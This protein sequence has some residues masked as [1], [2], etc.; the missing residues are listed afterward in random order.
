MISRMKTRVST[1]LMPQAIALVVLV[2]LSLALLVLTLLPSPAAAQAPAPAPGAAASGA[3][4]TQGRDVT[5][6][7][8]GPADGPA[9]GTTIEFR[10]E[11]RRFIS[12]ISAYARKNRPGFTVLTLN[13]LDLLTKKLAGDETK[14]YPARA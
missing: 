2:L 6:V 14:R 3:I 13:G 12:S 9:L 8:Q 7:Q 4:R 10:D 11:M 1:Q 5:P